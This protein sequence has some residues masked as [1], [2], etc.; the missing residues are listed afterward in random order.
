V[1]LAQ[2]AVRLVAPIRLRHDI[3]LL[4]LGRPEIPELR[5]DTF[6]V[7]TEVARERPVYVMFA[8]RDDWTNDLIEDCRARLEPVAQW[9]IDGEPVLLIY[10]WTAA[11]S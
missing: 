5:P 2:H 8:L 3:G 11:G 4:D 1:P 6:S 7:L 9:R 10:H